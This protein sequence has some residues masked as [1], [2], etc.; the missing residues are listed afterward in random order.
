MNWAPDSQD[1]VALAYL[2]WSWAY[3]TAG[4]CGK[5]QRSAGPSG[6]S[7]TLKIGHSLTEFF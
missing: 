5:R 7:D 2:L 1:I 4:A 6:L 3:A